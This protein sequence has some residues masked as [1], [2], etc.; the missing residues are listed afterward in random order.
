MTIV[1]FIVCE[2][3]EH[4]R[5]AQRL[6][7]EVF[8]V[9]KEWVDAEACEDGI[10]TDPSDPA[11]VHFLAL[12][13]DVPVGTVRLLLGW[14]HELPATRFLDLSPLNLEPTQVA[15]VSRL[16]TKRHGRSQDLRIFL[17][18]NTVMWEWGTAHQVKVWLAIA[19]M[20]LYHMLTR[21]GM[22]VVAEAQPVQYLGSLCVPV[23]FDMPGTGDVLRAVRQ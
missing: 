18:L 9:E 10:E 2:E 19:D 20:P 21:L 16:A 1:R 7:Y 11:A 6:R 14:R 15:E 5:E 4:I 8:C 23:A 13:G 12:D 3:P 17:G 22:P